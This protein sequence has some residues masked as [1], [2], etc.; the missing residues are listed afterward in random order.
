ML[1]PPPEEPEEVV[2]LAVPN[3]TPG[4]S[5]GAYYFRPAQSGVHKEHGYA[6]RGEA[7]DNQGVA[8]D[9]YNYPRTSLGWMTKETDEPGSGVLP[10]LSAI[11]PEG[12][13]VG[14]GYGRLYRGAG[15]GPYSGLRYVRWRDKPGELRGIIEADYG[16]EHDER[17][18]LP[19]H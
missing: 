1:N 8:F 11:R 16:W 6:P 2:R 15:G 10:Q 18:P 4:W 3:V 17:M 7:V 19:G 13:T 9:K 5:R 14:H 12:G